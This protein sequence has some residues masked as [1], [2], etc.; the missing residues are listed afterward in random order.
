MLGQM[1]RPSEALAAYEQARAIQQKLA[2]A[3]PNVTE[4]QSELARIHNNIG[5]L[6]C[7][8]GQAGRG[9]GGVGEGAGDP[10]GVGRRQP[11][12]DRVP[13]R[14]G[15]FA[16]RDRRIASRRGPCGRGGRG[17]P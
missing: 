8:D 15:D 11:P 16:F 5:T 2:D 13:A 3:N 12:R 1:G 14:P 10:A 9:A 17:L 7:G 4:F 6:L